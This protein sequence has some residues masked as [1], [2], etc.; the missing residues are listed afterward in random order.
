[1]SPQGES[2]TALMG[3]LSLQVQRPDH[4]TQKA[5]NSKRNSYSLP[6]QVENTYCGEGNQLTRH[7][8]EIFFEVQDGGL[9][10]QGRAMGQQSPFQRGARG[11]GG[12][13]AIQ[14]RRLRSEAAALAAAHDCK[15]RA[16]LTEGPAPCCSVSP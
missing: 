7:D 5:N 14:H 4:T 3:T 9:R 10:S 12:G 6:R 13:A 16:F 2:S 8:H 15:P 1:M 11:A